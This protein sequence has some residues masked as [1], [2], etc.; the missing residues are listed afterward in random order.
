[1]PD[2]VADET[3]IS[4]PVSGR[5]SLLSREFAG[6]FPVLRGC[7][8]IFSRQKPFTSAD[9]LRKFPG[10]FSREFFRLS[11]EFP[12]LLNLLSREIRSVEVIDFEW[13][14]LQAVRLEQAMQSWPSPSSTA[15]F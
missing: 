12:S 2:S 5:K 10:E 15:A 11:R 3:V 7:W 9:L 13:V 6:N 14:G 1:M 8:A 4:E